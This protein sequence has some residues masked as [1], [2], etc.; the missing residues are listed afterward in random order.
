MVQFTCVYANSVQNGGLSNYWPLATI[1]E[2]NELETCSLW[3]YY[4]FIAA[5]VEDGKVPSHILIFG[6]N[7]HQKHL[8]WL[9]KKTLEDYLFT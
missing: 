7:M 3:Y 8:I 2:R 1:S 9:Y 4:Y 5:V 6:Q